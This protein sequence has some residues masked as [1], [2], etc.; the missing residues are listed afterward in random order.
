MKL[1]RFSLT[2]IFLLLL[3]LAI[4]STAVAQTKLSSCDEIKKTEDFLALADRRAIC[5]TGSLL[6][7]RFDIRT[8]KPQ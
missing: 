8:L 5:L 1:N 7:T 6:K 3:L 2:S 4:Q